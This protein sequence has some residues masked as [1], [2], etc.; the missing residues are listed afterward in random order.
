MVVLEFSDGEQPD[1]PYAPHSGRLLRLGPDNTRT[2]VLDQLHY[3]TAMAFSPAG[4]LYIAVGGAFS[5]A[6]EGAI[7][8]LR[9]RQLGAPASCSREHVQATQ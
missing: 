3:P 7:L 6:G 5:E 9:C 8:Q 2:V 4:D 1:Q